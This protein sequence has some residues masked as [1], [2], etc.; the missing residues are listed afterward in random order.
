MRRREFIA[1][2]G[3]AAA[4]WPLAVRAEQASTPVVGFLGL[5][6]SSRNENVVVAIRQGLAEAGFVEGRTVAIQER[7]AYGN[8]RRLA[9]LA[10][11][12][13]QRKVAVI[14]AIDGGPAILAAK[15]ATS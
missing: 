4:S 15:A 1:G 6:S 14:V 5:W 3:G 2:L 12:L 10:A 8:G 11:E 13:V 9:P 7:W